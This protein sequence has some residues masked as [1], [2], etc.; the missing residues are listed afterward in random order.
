MAVPFQCGQ[1]D[2]KHF[3][4]HIIAR[5]DAVLAG[6]SSAQTSG[7]QSGGPKEIADELADNARHV[8]RDL[9]QFWRGDAFDTPSFHTHAGTALFPNVSDLDEW[10]LTLDTRL[11][12]TGL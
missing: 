12:L 9:C 10:L 7:D 4:D 3:L 2:R 5:T 11:Q 1:H 8:L 6:F